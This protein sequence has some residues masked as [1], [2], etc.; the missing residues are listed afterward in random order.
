MV[1]LSKARWFLYSC[2]YGEELAKYV[3]Q[4]FRSIKQSNFFMLTAYVKN[5]NTF[6]LC[7]THQSNNALSA[8]LKWRWFLFFFLFS[9]V[10]VW[11]FFKIWVIGG[12][13]YFS[14]TLWSGHALYMKNSVSTQ[15]SKENSVNMMSCK[16]NMCH[17]ESAVRH[18]LLVSQK[19]K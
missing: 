13:C 3:Y 8:R 10:C 5:S 17:L 15:K 9:C 16:P 2:G 19:N 4:T 14:G 1:L 18:L 7:E 6:R 12:W 11:F